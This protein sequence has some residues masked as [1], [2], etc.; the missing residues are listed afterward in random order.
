MAGE[1]WISEVH[2]QVKLQQKILQGASDAN[3]A[4]QDL[5]RL[6]FDMGFTER[7]KGSHHI[8]M[9]EDVEEIL[10]LQPKGQN[11]KPY[12]VRTGPQHHLTIPTGLE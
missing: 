11:A 10:N 4:F 1:G 8:F 5:R 9:K 2:R 12:Q 6:L 3:I 7:I